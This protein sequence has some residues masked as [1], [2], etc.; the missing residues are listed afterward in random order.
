MSS[1]V[2]MPTPVEVGELLEMLLGREVEAMPSPP[3]AYRSREHFR[4]AVYLD[5]HNHIT[6]ALVCDAALAVRASAALSLLPPKQTDALVQNGEMDE[7]MRED[8]SEI[9]NVATRLFHG[10]F[11]TTVRVARIFEVPMQAPQ[12][13]FQLMGAAGQRQDIELDIR[14]YAPGRAARFVI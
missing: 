5:N 8:L 9:C 10:S 3:T 7:S 4:A 12:Q 2:E 14:G 11:S 6:G 13:L 1:D